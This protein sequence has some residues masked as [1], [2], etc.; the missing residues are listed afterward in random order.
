MGIFKG[1]RYKDSNFYY[2]NV[3]DKIYMGV[4]KEKFL[5]KIDDL[6]ILFTADTRLDLLA[7]KYYKDPQLD[8]VILQANPQYYSPEDILAGDLIIIPAPWRVI[9]NI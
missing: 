7:Q 1:S 4:P 9:N 3:Y 2:D 6:T 5:P 8:W